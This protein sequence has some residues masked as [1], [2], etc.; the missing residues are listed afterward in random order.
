M[1]KQEPVMSMN[2]RE[3]GFTAVELLITLFVAAAFLVASYQLFNLII[4]DGGATRAQSRAAN[5]AY[6]YLRQYS[7]SSTTI[8]CT[9]SSPLN[10]AP[11]TVDGLSDVTISVSITCLPDAINS[12]SKV[13]ADISFN[14]PQQTVSYAL[15]TS[16]AGASNGADITNGLVAWWKLNGDAN[17]SVGSGNG[18]INGALSTSGQ[19]GIADTAYLFSASSLQNITA[20]LASPTG[21]LTLSAWIRPTALPT[22]KSTIIETTNPLGN[23]MSLSSDSSLALYRYGATPSGYLTSGAGTISLNQWNLATVT[24]DG[25]MAKLYVNGSLLNTTPVTGTGMSSTGVIIGAE[26]TGRQF[27]GSIDDVRMY[28]RTLSQA[29]ILSLYSAGAQ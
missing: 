20:N 24:W 18:T 10:D 9:A 2:K 14:N 15:Y 3:S 25:A 21:P 26:N 29:E 27:V 5:V 23:Y 13:E 4:K 17:N 12:L 7:A 28:N 6:D 22:D 1:D 11:I 16:S 8:P 19:A